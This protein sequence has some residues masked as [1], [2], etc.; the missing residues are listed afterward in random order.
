VVEVRNRLPSFR[1]MAFFTLR[2]QLRAM[3]VAGL[4]ATDAIRAEF[5]CAQRP[6]MTGVTLQLGMLTGKLPMSVARVIEVD[7]LPFRRAMAAGAVG[8][9]SS[10]V[11]ILPLMATIA[12]LR[13][14]G[15]HVSRSMT[16]LAL[17]VRML[18]LQCKSG[19]LGVIE[20]R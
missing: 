4:V 13:Y 15:L 6:G 5:A 2:S 17:Q 9:E 8:P 18:A 16:V 3:H 11:C 19:F 20:L 12:L 10:G 7:R 1:Q 14:S